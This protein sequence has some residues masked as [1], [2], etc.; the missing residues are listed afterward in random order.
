MAK[1]TRKQGRSFYLGVVVLVL[2]V[3]TSYIS[4][5]ADQGLPGMPKTV[6]R[7]AFGDVGSLTSGADVRQNS[8]RIGRVASVE[9]VNGLP[10]VTMELDGSQPVYRNARA[11]IWDQSALS[12]KFVELLPGDPSAPPLG[13]GVIPAQANENSS[14]ISRLF[15]VLDDPTRAAT[16]SAVRELGDGMAGH[17]RD[18]HDLLGALP[19]LLNDTGV[20]STALASKEADLPALLAS[21]DR[22][23]GRF[24]GRDNDLSTLVTQLDQTLQAVDVDG[25]GPL[26][27]VLDKAPDLLRHGTAAADSLTQPLADAREAVTDL[28]SGAKALGD[29]TPDF[30]GVLREAPGTLGKVPAVAGQAIPAVD[31]LTQTFSDLRPLVIRLGDGLPALRSLLQ[32]LAPYAPE[33]GDFGYHGGLVFAGH[34]G[35]RHYMRVELVLPGLA[36]LTAGVS[37][38]DGMTPVPRNPYPAPGQDPQDRAT[39]PGL[40]GGRN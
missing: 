4:L 13:D 36:G 27:Q 10:Q 30:R 16:T 33:I 38:L 23:A 7:A 1:V 34:A 19:S 12:Q 35:D 20:V 26:T 39:A 5:T 15:D 8:V 25:G 22:L 37:P 21:A 29:A 14:D 17:S 3:V 31:N 32:T 2:A 18:L 28:R 40:L 9:E 24:S 11:A 6:V